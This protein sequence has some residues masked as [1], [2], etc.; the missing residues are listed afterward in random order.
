MPTNKNILRLKQILSD[1]S[2][3]FER[4]NPQQRRLA[5]IGGGALLL[6]LVYLAVISP[7]LSLHDS[8]SQDLARKRQLLTK[9][10]SLVASKARIEQGNKAMKA[11]LAQAEKQFLTGGNPA[12]AS[13]DLQ[14]ILKKLTQDNGVSM[15]STKVLQPREA[16]PYL[17]VPVQAQL[18][19]T[20]AQLLT[21]LYQL[22]HHKKLLFIP[23]LEI[24]APRW[25]TGAKGPS[26]LQVNLVVSGVIKKSK[27]VSS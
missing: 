27:G 3:Q 16:G 7:L 18:A 21:I 6:V 13:A 8:W 5:W 22:E 19:C 14:E 4:L 12:V 25:M 10:E 11:T 15:T 2:R 1:S 9:Y 26:T 20:T 23:E 17:E 24:N